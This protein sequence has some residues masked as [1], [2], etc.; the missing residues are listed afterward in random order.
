MLVFNKVIV[1]V[2]NVESQRS[3][4]VI[5]DLFHRMEFM[6]RRGSGL[7]DIIDETAKLLGYLEKLQTKF[8]SS[9]SSFKVII[10][11][12]NYLNELINEPI[13]LSNREK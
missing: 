2:M 3:N 10:N 11:N 9:N 7:R 12:V 8:V 1:E 6:E 5:A 13:N 4:P